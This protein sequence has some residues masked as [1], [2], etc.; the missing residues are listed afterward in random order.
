M[1]KST[2]RLVMRHNCQLP[3]RARGH[4]MDM[5]DN[6]ANIGGRRRRNYLIAGLGAL[7]IGLILEVALISAEL[8]SR[9]FSVLFVPFWIAALGLLQARAA[10]CVRLAVRNVR[11]MGAGET[12]VDD[13]D[14]ALQ[15][16]AAARRIHFEAMVAA[17]I[18]TGISLVVGVAIH[19]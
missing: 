10:I 12:P 1:A 9:W 5:S 15:L 19:G 2:G 3:G 16:R 7:F 4:T 13:E 8:E 18:L 17:T 14:E 11:N 6:V